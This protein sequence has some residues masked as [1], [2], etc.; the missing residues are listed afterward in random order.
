MRPKRTTKGPGLCLALVIFAMFAPGTHAQEL[1]PRAYTNLPIGMNFVLLGFAESRGDLSTD[2][3]VPIEDAQL[4]ID[5]GLFAYARSLNLWG[6]SGKFDI[7]IPYSSLSGSAL[8][9][10]VPREREVSG[11]GDPRIRLSMNLYGAPALS[12]AQY[13]SYEPDLVIGASVQ[14]SVPLGQNDPDRL[15]NLGSNRWAVKT[16]LGFSKPLGRLMFDLTAGA[17]FFSDNDDFFGGQRLEQDP[18]YSAQANLS[19]E[20][21][22]KVW[23]ALGLSYYWGGRSTIDGVEK[24]N[25]L[26]NSRVGLTVSVPIDKNYSIKFNA[27][28]GVV[29]RMG[30]G[31]DIVGFALQ[32]RWGEGYGTER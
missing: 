14:V 20:F 15:I 22:N 31:F 30:T 1:E 12:M 25:E 5:T 27:S 6:N 7:I 13:R 17:T 19:Y 24:D 18:V 16:D 9:A 2:P 3:S 21:D 23:V 32:Y 4:E 11:F 28:T 29:T 26:G 10:G 8:V